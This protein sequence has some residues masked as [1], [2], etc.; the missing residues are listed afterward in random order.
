MSTIKTSSA[1][2]GS[3]KLIHWYTFPVVTSWKSES[4]IIGL[5]VLD[6]LLFG[7]PLSCCIL[8][9]KRIKQYKLCRIRQ[10]T[11]FLSFWKIKERGQ[12]DRSKDRQNRRTIKR[13]NTD[14]C[15]KRCRLKGSRVDV[16]LGLEHPTSKRL[17]ILIM[18]SK[19]LTDPSLPYSN[20]V[21]KAQFLSCE[22]P[23]NNSCWR[24]LVLHNWIVILRFPDF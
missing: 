21:R 10:V 6:K 9:E 17:N 8:L 4:R 15:T 2:F 24:K 19:I 16:N 13:R 7:F 3:F 12:K 14:L 23:H 22:M 20:N 18:N 11:I 1:F 5:V